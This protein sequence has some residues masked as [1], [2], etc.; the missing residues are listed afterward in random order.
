MTQIKA[1][2]ID[3]TVRQERSRLLNFIRQFVNSQDE[4]YAA[5]SPERM[6]S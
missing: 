2:H 6:A 5:A 4:F 1:E 3:Q